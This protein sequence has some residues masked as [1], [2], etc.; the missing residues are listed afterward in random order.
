[1][2]E[3]RRKIKRQTPPGGGR[4]DTL[5]R[6]LQGDSASRMKIDLDAEDSQSSEGSGRTPRHRRMGKGKTPQHLGF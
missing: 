1:M 6:L 2:E 3:A 4:V 5:R